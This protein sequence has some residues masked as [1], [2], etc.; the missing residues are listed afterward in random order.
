MAIN[1]KRQD[2]TDPLEA[3]KA[4][5]EAL[6]RGVPSIIFDREVKKHSWDITGIDLLPPQQAEDLAFIDLS[7]VDRLGTIHILEP[8]TLDRDLSLLARSICAWLDGD[9]GKIKEFGLADHVGRIEDK[10]TVLE[11]MVDLY[12]EEKPEKA[13]K[14]LGGMMGVKAWRKFLRDL[15][16]GLGSLIFE[17]LWFSSL[18][19]LGLRCIIPM[20]K[21]LLLVPLFS[22][23]FP[24]DIAAKILSMILDRIFLIRTKKDEAHNLNIFLAAAQD[25]KGDAE[26]TLHQLAEIYS[27][28]NFD[29]TVHQIDN[30]QTTRDDASEYGRQ[31]WTLSLL[32]YGR[33]LSILQAEWRS[34]KGWPIKIK[35][36]D[37]WGNLHGLMYKK[38]LLSEFPEEKMP[39]AI[40]EIHDTGFRLGCAA[41]TIEILEEL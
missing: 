39:E 18:F 19:L 1:W 3:R 36:F 28:D 32:K 14:V 33:D 8:E 30:Y 29:I 40:Q 4:L 35:N 12:F 10:L 37:Y 7:A 22:H 16:Q 9:Q 26:K 21:P 25:L 31:L 41:P 6:E 27:A 13:I 38:Q 15:G 34:I 24:K 20:D 5:Q 23:L 2:H 11:F 17:D